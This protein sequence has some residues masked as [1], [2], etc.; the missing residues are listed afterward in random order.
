[1]A[2]GTIQKQ[3]R[4]LEYGQFSPTV[5]FNSID[6]NEIIKDGRICTANFNGTVKNAASAVWLKI[7]EVPDGFR[8]NQDNSK[9][10]SFV[11]TCG[12]STVTRMVIGYGTQSQGYN[13]VYCQNKY[14]SG[15]IISFSVVWIIQED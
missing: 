2:T 4:N 3:T 6:V 11:G 12:D 10:V 5:Q 14:S 1:M 9:G 8:I 7:L 13:G 15:V